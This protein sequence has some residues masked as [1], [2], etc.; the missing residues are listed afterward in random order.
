MERKSIVPHYDIIP[1]AKPRMTRRDQWLTP[2]RKCVAKYWAFKEECQLKK[3]KIPQPCK[4]VFFIPMPKSWSKKRKAAMIGE[5]HLQVPDLDN[6]EKA[7]FDAVYEDDAHI[8]NVWGVKVWSEIG[9]IA[10]SPMK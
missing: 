9:G 8:W 10:I 7:L 2:P 5:P 3:L 4:I 1:N 6:I